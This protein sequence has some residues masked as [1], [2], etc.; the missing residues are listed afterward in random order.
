MS[1]L[2]VNLSGVNFH[3]LML[4]REGMPKITHENLIVL[5]VE[6]IFPRLPR[7]GERFP[8]SNAD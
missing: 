1:E 7:G 8:V 3:A 5:N 2:V 6:L 4:V